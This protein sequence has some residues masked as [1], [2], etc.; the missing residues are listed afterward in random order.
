MV[1]ALAV[2]AAIEGSKKTNKLDVCAIII[3]LAA[4]I[5]FTIGYVRRDSSLVG[6][7]Y[8]YRINGIPVAGG[9]VVFLKAF[10]IGF[11]GTLIAAGIGTGIGE[12]IPKATEKK[13]AVEKF[14][15]NK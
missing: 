10:G 3:I 14:R 1:L 11:L 4:C 2:V 9:V 6:A 8:V 15:N 5:V 12:R 7:T 13:A